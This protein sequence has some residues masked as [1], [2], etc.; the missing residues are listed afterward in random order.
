RR[1]ASPER[2]GLYP[3]GDGFAG[4]GCGR[5]L[6]IALFSGNYVHIRDGVSLT[7]NRLVRYLEAHGHEVLVFAPTVDDAPITPAGAFVPVPSVPAPGRPEYRLSVAFPKAARA[8]LEA[9][10]PDLVHIATPDY[11]GI[12]AVR[13][14]KKHS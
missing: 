13:W 7:L 11:L 10:R 12:R 5:G 1:G 4:D 2:Q 9:F 8:Q 14:A 3:A 6:R